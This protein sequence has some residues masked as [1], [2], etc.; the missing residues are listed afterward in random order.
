MKKISVQ[1]IFP[2]FLLFFF[3][4][5]AMCI[6][7]GKNH[8]MS[9]TAEGYK[10]GGF[11]PWLLSDKFPDTVAENKPYL[12]ID[13]KVSRPVGFQCYW[14]RKDKGLH[15]TRMHM[16]NVS[17]VGEYVTKVIDLN[18]FGRFK[19][20]DFIRLGPAAAGDL[21]FNIKEAKFLSKDEVPNEH[22]ATLVEM[23]SFTSKLHYLPNE[24]IEYKVTMLAKNYP[25]IKSSKILKAKIVN[26]K[27]NVIHESLQHY[28]IAEIE[29]RKELYG[30]FVPE[31]KLLPGKYVLQVESSD[32]MIDFVIDDS[33]TFGVIDDEFPFVYETPFKYVKDFTLIRDKE[34]LWHIFSITGDFVENHDWIPTGNERTFSHGTSKDLR[35]WEYHEP[36]LSISY[37]KYDNGGEFYEDKGVWAPNVIYHNGLYYMFYTSTNQSVSQSISLA[38]SKDL[39]KWKKCDKNPVFNLEGLEWANWGKNR[40]AD[41]RDPEILADGGKFYM[42]VTAHAAS[43]NPRGMVVVADSNDLVKWENPRIAV[44]YNHAM[45]SCQVWK[46][47]DKYFMTTSAHGGGVWVSDRPDEGWEKAP[48]GRPD[49]HKYEKLVQTSPSYAEEVLNLDDLDVIAGLTWRHFGNSIYIFKINYGPTG[50]PVSYQSPFELP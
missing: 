14:W 48:I 15:F 3:S 30:C 29:N 24:R 1:Y 49:V 8:S 31:E 28:G 10:V 23:K 6:N 38:T 34:G 27:G 36:V 11:D 2:L 32:Q 40:W 46:H 25:E 4:E 12:S 17:K 20:A 39:F 45:E 50:L 26:D 9:R 22:F 13:I 43:G 41:C 47:K 16:I 37:E 19:G 5:T 7:F 21:T 33:H 35:Q 44:R 42:Y 18:R